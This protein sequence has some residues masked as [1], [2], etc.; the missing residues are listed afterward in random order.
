MWELYLEFLDE[1]LTEFAIEMCFL[2]V[3]ALFIG[4]KAVQNSIKERIR[5]K[6]ALEE[7]RE[8]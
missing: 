8:D 3:I 4:V 7:S 2:L 6:R 1:G 5:Y